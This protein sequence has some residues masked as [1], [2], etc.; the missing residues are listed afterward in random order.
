[1][2]AA[3]RSM[4]AGGGY[5]KMLLKQRLKRKDNLKNENK[6]LDLKSN[7]KLEFFLLNKYTS[8]TSTLTL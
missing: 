3:T 5:Q 4:G 2:R 7:E 6:K 8:P 1:M